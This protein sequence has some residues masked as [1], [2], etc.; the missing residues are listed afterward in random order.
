M[1][2][3]R[4]RSPASEPARMHRAWLALVDADGPFLAL[5]ALNRVYP[6][7]IPA[8]APRAREALRDAKPAFDRAWDAYQQEREAAGRSAAADAAAA[9]A[10]PAYRE[11]RDTWVDTVLRDV[12]GWGEYSNPATGAL[13]AAYAVTSPDGREQVTPTSALAVEGRVGALVLVVDPVDDLREILP[14]SWAASPIDRMESMLRAPDSACTIGVVTDGRWWALVSA[15]PGTMLASGI[16]DALTWV[17]EPETRDALIE[18]LSIRRLLGGKEKDRLPSLFAE[19]VLAAEE[20]T[21]ALGVQVRRAVELLVAAFSEAGRAT[22]QHE[23][24][25]PLP[26]DAGEVYDAAV[27]VMMRVV[28]LLFAEERDLLP[29]TA[30]FQRGYGMAGVLEA[31]EERERAEGEE[32]LENTARAWHRLLATSRALAEGANF[33]DTRLPAY[34][35]SLFD[36][37]RFPFLTATTARGTL[38]ISIPDRV[39]LHVLRAVQVARTAG[40]EARRIS[41]RDIDVE[42]IGYVYEGLLGYTCRRADETI[43]G[44]IGKEGNEP[45]VPLRVLDDLAEEHT[46][47]A[48]LA[49]AILAWVKADQPSLEKKLVS[50]SK[51]AKALAA[52]DAP[53]DAERA[54]IQVSRGDQA[55]R[56]SLKPWIGAIRHDLR[57]RPTV[58]QPGDLIVVETPSRKNAGAHYTPRS[59]AEDVV[60]HALEPLVYQP[61]PYQTSERSRWRLLPAGELLQLKVADIACGSGAFLVAAARYLAERLVEA[62]QEE[63]LAE[64]SPAALERRALREV[65]ASCLYGVD[66]NPMAIEMCKLS[67]WLVSLD[68]DLPFSFVDHKVRVG[69]SLL[70]ITDLRQVERLHITPAQADGQGLFDIDDGAHA[71]DGLALADLMKDT[72]DELRLL[73]EPVSENDPQRSTRAKVKGLARIDDRTALARRVADGVI[74]AGLE[75]GGGPGRRLNE[76][77][78]DLM[79]AVERCLRVEKPDGAMLNAII[80]RGLSPTVATDYQRWTCLH[81]PL[82]FPDVMNRG[83]FDAIVGNPPFLGGQKLTGAMGQNV[84]DWYVNV[85]GDGAKGPA[86][87]VAYFFLRAFTL[88]RLTGTL[89]LIATNTVAQGRTREVG[90]DRMA[91]RGF[92]ITRAIQSEAWPADS[93]HLEYAA[94]WGT[95]GEVSAQSEIVCDGV[96]VRRISTLLD[97]VGRVEGNPERL[98][99]NADA[100][101]QGCIVL[102]KGFILDPD[103]AAAWIEKDPRNA[104]VIFPYLNGVD[105]NSRPD[106]SASRWVIDFNDWPAGRAARYAVPYGRLVRAVKPVRQRTKSD[107]SYAL[108]K[109]LPE[110]WWQYGEKRPAMRRAIAGL[111]EALVIARVSGTVM[112]ARVPCNQVFD[113]KLVVFAKNSYA[114]QAILSSSLHQCW[115][116]KYG[117]TRTGDPT[118][119]PTTVFETF[120]RPESSEALDAIGRTLDTER[121]EIMLRRSLGLTR[122]YNLVNDPGLARD[123]DL[124][125]DRMREIHRELDRIVAAAYGWDDIPLDHGFHTYRKTTRWTISPTARVE[126]LDRLLEENRRRAA[127]SVS[128]PAR[129]NRA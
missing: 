67:L 51:L 119:T 31:L 43:L 125:V 101:F 81:W 108:R 54:L 120:P 4:R 100:A 41:F 39:M 27:T 93:A 78:E 63:G 2:P 18:L 36:A 99:E 76:A 56:A 12:L 117:T 45:E 103:E 22:V 46:D 121:R 48:S 44:L 116:I 32:S 126:L 30:L 14:G 10:L 20:I 34:G 25:D 98:T 88:L 90:L 29:G 105:L 110:R 104:E 33:E 6:D 8:S 102:G 9:D 89:G 11:A 49:A 17:E 87:L 37:S 1:S 114:T 92:T 127:E 65:V 84:R 124:D 53:E 7:G 85:L 122:L 69:N 61:G 109:P 91:E 26:D 86:D 13:S 72:A 21:E 95:K 118:Y 58:F 73:S 57:G 106:C 123:T 113:D 107:G 80:E 55:L 111:D 16:V 3:T 59:L 60:I 70:G 112:P 50:S 128:R 52:G 74:A 66:I 94:V 96:L 28:F 19:S 38:T 79:V 23:G 83:G 5:P 62:W 75:L 82:V 40:H 129:R 68:P 115:A 71:V 47:D 42:Q 97:P 77:Y 64:E 15:A 24:A 35:G